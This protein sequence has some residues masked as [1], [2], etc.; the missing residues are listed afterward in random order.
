MG[1]TRTRRNPVLVDEY[2]GP[3]KVQSS[4]DGFW[5]RMIKDTFSKSPG[6]VFVF[7]DV[8]T[9]TAST[10]RGTYG[11]D[12]Y[13]V[14]PDGPDGPVELHVR[15]LPD[16]V[17]RIKQETKDRGAKRKATIAANKAAGKTSK[18]AK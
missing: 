2:D 12:A 9:S 14:R 1:D 18:S 5:G 15:Y 6:K 10:L 13:T 8:S 3:V 11:L 7:G 4:K 17:D 16:Q